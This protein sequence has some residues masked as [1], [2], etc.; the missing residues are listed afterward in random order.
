M[1]P[2]Q[3]DRY[4]TEAEKS[5][6]E[7]FHIVSHLVFALAEIQVPIAPKLRKA[8]DTLIQECGIDRKCWTDI[9]RL[10]YDAYWRSQ[11][12]YDGS[13]G[14]DASYFRPHSPSD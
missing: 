3:W 12:G 10:N 6:G 1:T 13:E 7:T 14:K 11:Y 5:A 2:E 4:Y 9:K 8:L